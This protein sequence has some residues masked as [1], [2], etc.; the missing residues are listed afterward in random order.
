MGVDIRTRRHEDIRE[1]GVEEIFDDCLT[2]AIDRH[3]D[4]AARGI[5]VNGF[6][7]CAKDGRMTSGSDQGPFGVSDTRRTP[8]LTT[9][10]WPSSEHRPPSCDKKR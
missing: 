5:D 1:L 2:S 9:D 6:T 10:Q 7:L 8:S 3:G 4:L